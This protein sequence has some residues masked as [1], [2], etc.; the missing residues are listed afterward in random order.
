MNSEIN[1]DIIIVTSV[2]YILSRATFSIKLLILNITRLSLA[3]LDRDICFY[4]DVFFLC[5][6]FLLT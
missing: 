5:T 1:N 4:I 2:L 3:C 6:Y